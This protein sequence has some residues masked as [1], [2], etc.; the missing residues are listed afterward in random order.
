MALNKNEFKKSMVLDAHTVDKYAP[1]KT[2]IFN[3]YL[4]EYKPGSKT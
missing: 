3:V 4:N 2:G 1:L